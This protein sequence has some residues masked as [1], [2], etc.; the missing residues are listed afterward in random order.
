M[1]LP[2]SN[3]FVE[4]QRG[5]IKHVPHIC[6]ASIARP[7]SVRPRRQR[8][9]TILAKVDDGLYLRVKAVHVPGIVI[10][11]VRRKPYAAVPDRTHLSIS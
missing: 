4:M 7:H 2:K 8:N 11:R 9:R 3:K 6:L 5:H 1:S 10:H